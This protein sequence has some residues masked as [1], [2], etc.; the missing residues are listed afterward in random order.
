M[1][2]YV[3]TMH[4]T[5]NEPPY[6]SHVGLVSARTYFLVGSITDQCFEQFVM[7]HFNQPQHAI[8]SALLIHLAKCSLTSLLQFFRKFLQQKKENN[9]SVSSV[10]FS[11]SAVQPWP[12][13]KFGN[14]ASIVGDHGGVLGQDILNHCVA[15]T[16]KIM[17]IDNSKK[18]KKKK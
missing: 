1:I 6:R 7:S 17:N 2:N 15:L 3:I 18:K 10:L 12:R 5:E 13:G 8:L 11:R 16:M 9:S 14:K 4:A